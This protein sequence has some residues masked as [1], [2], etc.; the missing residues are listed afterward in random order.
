M[1]VQENKGGVSLH[2][3]SAPR[4][5]QPSRGQAHLAVELPHIRETIAQQVRV[6][7]PVVSNNESSTAPGKGD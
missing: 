1:Y 5:K 3:S 2:R 7:I 6:V 4:D